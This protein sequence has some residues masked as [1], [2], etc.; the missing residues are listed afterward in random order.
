MN[1]WIPFSDGEYMV[2]QALLIAGQDRAVSVEDVI[3]GG[4]ERVLRTFPVLSFEVVRESVRGGKPPA[5]PLL[6][7]L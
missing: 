4:T 2:E 3:P 7:A 1:N 5:H 6:R